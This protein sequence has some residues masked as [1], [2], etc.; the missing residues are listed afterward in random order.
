MINP[1]PTIIQVLGEIIDILR[2]KGIEISSP[3]DFENF[4]DYISHIN[5]MATGK[6]EREEDDWSKCNRVIN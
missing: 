1:D 2:D 5:L 3:Y 6:F 4:F